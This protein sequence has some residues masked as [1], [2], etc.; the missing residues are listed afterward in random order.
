MAP[1]TT[2]YPAVRLQRTIPAPPE[3]VY[4]AWLDPEL[5]RRWLAPSS[6]EVTDVEV[7]E[8]VGGHYRIWQ[9]SP[10]GEVGGVV[11]AEEDLAAYGRCELSEAVD[12]RLHGRQVSCVP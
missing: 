10:D 11:G 6:W 12:A 5:L 9:R 1:T 7:D 4:R 3:R 8:R 2:D